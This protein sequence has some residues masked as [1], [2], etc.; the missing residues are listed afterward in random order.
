MDTFLNNPQLT[1]SN[2]I[3]SHTIFKN[4][5]V[6]GNVIVENK[7]NSTNLR[8]I[9]EDV[10]LQSDQPIVIDSM[11][12]FQK[13]IITDKSVFVNSGFINERRL[14]DLLTIDTEQDI[15]VESM[16]GNIKFQNI[17]VGGTFDQVNI[18]DLMKNSV[19]LNEDQIV[20]S[21][22]TFGHA[23]E[24]SSNDF[25]L[26]DELFDLE[27]ENIEI[28]NTCNDWN[29]EMDAI[30]ITKGDFVLNQA[31]FEHLIVDHLTVKG[32]MNIL[33]KISGI[34]LEEFDNIR[35]S[36]TENRIITAPAAIANCTAKNMDFQFINDYSIDEIRMFVNQSK[37]VEQ[38]ILAGNIQ[39]GKLYIK[40]KLNVELINGMN[41][42]EMFEEA[43]WLKDEY[44]N[45]V[46]PG[47]VIFLNDVYFDEIKIGGNVYGKNFD[48]YLKDIVKK[49]DYE[50]FI[51]GKK[52]FQN[53]L[54]I[55]NYANITRFNEIPL[56]KLLNYDT[57]QI[58]QS[59]IYFSGNV[60]INNLDVNGMI[61]GVF[62][63][64]ILKSF[65]YLGDNK[66]QFSNNFYMDEN[67]IIENL[68]VK[69]LLNDK[70][71]LNQFLHTA[72]M[73]NSDIHF[74]KPLTFT[75]KVYINDI[76]D[77][78]IYYNGINVK[79]LHNIVTLDENT[80]INSHLLFVH[81]V[82][83]EKSLI[84]EKNINCNYIQECNIQ[85]WITNFMSLTGKQHVP[86]KICSIIDSK[87]L[88]Q[89]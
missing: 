70:Y 82:F 14:T 10:I 45:D 49:S 19:K 16:R 30:D 35:L 56:A 32:N 69:G 62:L 89:K 41:L 1:E 71:N 63:K 40:G 88:K 3:N 8:N 23:E 55:Q 72:I 2:I 44:E 47:K 84:V 67:V 85:E 42:K 80:L 59:D 12:I 86:G 73:K 26:N 39:I 38:E 34:N 74:D 61:N 29:V 17:N 11:K 83:I 60:I 6:E 21:Q 64:D 48:D 57:E 68:F 79:N 18:S 75:G 53:G 4:L 22:L 78:K 51:T 20:L 27:A 13:N 46:I 65:Q 33:D 31:E 15:D 25:Q 36:K 66:Y 7:F 52:V 87:I 24:E 50:I 76:L 43:I 37:N 5:R 54:S 9:L 77:V 81:P 58:V 28:I